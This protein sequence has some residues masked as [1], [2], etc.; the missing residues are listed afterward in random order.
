MPVESMSMRFLIGMV[1]A[2]VTPGI[3]MEAFIWSMSLSGVM[4]GRHSASGLSVMVVSTME[5]GAGSV[6]V[7]ARPILPKTCSTSGKGLM[8]LSVCWSISRALV[9]EMPG[10]VVGM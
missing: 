9:A 6:A 3:C 1:Q 2:L 5:R 7:S 4:P 8:I 10:S